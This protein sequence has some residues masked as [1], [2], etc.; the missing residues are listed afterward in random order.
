MPLTTRCSP[1]TT[2]TL[3]YVAFSLSLSL[4][5][6][7]A[8]NETDDVARLLGL[9]GLLPC[10]GFRTVEQSLVAGGET[11]FDLSWPPSTLGFDRL[12]YLRRRTG[13]GGVLSLSLAR[14]RSFSF[15]LF[16]MLGMK[17]SSL[18]VS[19]TSLVRYNA[20][21]TCLRRVQYNSP[22]LLAGL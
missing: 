21:R 17:P 14:S 8:G 4:P 13:V 20:L 6:P 3:Y 16:R 1:H 12:R 11:C 10:H 22:V 19:E 9:A 15:V 5:L 7:N 2:G 18:S